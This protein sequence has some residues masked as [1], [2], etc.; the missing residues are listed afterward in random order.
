MVKRLAA[1]PRVGVGDRAELVVGILKEVG[2]DRADPQPLL[3]QMPGE[4][5][6]ALGGVP[7]KVQGD[8][9]GGGG[10]A[11]HLGGVVDSLEHVARSTGLRKD[12]EAG[13]RVPVTP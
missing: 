3:P 12:A 2:V 4:L 8:G 7:R 9:R 13:A 5:V 6:K 1:D 11:V 10:Q